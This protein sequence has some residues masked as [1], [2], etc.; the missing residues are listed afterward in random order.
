VTGGQDGT[1]RVWDLA[2]GTELF[3]CTGHTQMVHGLALSPDG[4]LILSAGWDGFV[5]LWDAH[6]GK[7]LRRFEDGSG[8]I[9]AVAFSPDGRRDLWKRGGHLRLIEIPSGKEVIAFDHGD[10]KTTVCGVAFS[11]DG[12]YAVSGGE[13][14]MVRLWRLPEPPPGGLAEEYRLV[15]HSGLV[16]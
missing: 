13:D 15:G 12:K 9:D 7:E 10:S 4:R 8:K 1:V 14:R 2:A 16:T 6:T 5:R 11:P 3:C